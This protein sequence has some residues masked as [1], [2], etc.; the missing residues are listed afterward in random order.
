MIRRILAALLTCRPSRALLGLAVPAALTLPVLAA[1]ACIVPSISTGSD[2]AGA[3]ATGSDAGATAASTA[4]TGASCTTI[5]SSISLCQSIS[6]CP[7]LALN[8]QVFPE[9]GFRI[10]GTAVDPECLC[11]N[12][13]LCPIGHPT[14]CAEAATDSSGDVNYDSVCQQEV[15][16]GC[17]DLTGASTGT[18]SSSSTA[19]QMCVNACDNVPSCI[20]A[21]GC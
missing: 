2:D 14:T 21:C 11:D 5:T 4:V 6:S 16:G 10:H 1:P 3:A 9:C 15:T 17:Q 20:D 19:C 7:S 13:Y 18:G 12:E 8:P